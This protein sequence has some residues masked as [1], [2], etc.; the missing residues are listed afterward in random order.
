MIETNKESTYNIECHDIVEAV[1]FSPYE[2][3]SDLLAIAT[4]ARI[5][6]G[7]CRFQVRFHL[8]SLLATTDIDC[9][10]IKYTHCDLNLINLNGRK[11][12]ISSM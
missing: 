6:V 7:S 12:V 2:W 3:S 11:Y 4:T 9:Q 10:L 1:E 8:K 5:S